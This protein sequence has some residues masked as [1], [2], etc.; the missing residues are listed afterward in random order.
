[1]LLET[2]NKSH[3]IAKTKKILILATLAKRPKIT[4]HTRVKACQNI[5]KKVVLLSNK[6]TNL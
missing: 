5:P 4:N 3:F 2:L 6:N 1:M